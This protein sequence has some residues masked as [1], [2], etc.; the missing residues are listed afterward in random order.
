[1]AFDATK[2]NTSQ[3][4][5]DTIVSTNTNLNALKEDQTT[6]EADLTAHGLSAINSSV[7]TTVAHISDLNAHGLPAE[8]TRISNLETEVIA[9]RGT[10]ASLALRLAVGML[11]TGAIKLSSISSKW[12]NNSDVP[13]YL[14]S[15]TFSVPGSRLG[16]YIAGVQL[17]LNIAGSYVYA[18]V[19]SSSFGSGVTTVTLD[20]AYPV[21]TNGITSVEIALISY[22]NNMAAS[23]ATVQAEQILQSSDI[24][25]L[26]LEMIRAHKNGTPT[27]SEVLTRFYV[28]RATS[29]PSG[30]AG[31]GAKALVAAT[32]STTFNIQKNGSTVGT[33]VFAAAGTAATVTISSSVSLA[34]GDLVTI[35]APAS[36]D[37]TLANL[38]IAVKGILV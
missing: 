7:A 11:P 19:A 30:A 25:L 21:L 12:I 26:Q 24:D 17:R 22:D 9:S 28:N 23:I 37:A 4:I 29:L 32:A 38:A 5:G 8:R 10:A 34:V 6:H 20:P 3:T 36:P 2:P 16:V 33:I 14:T 27:A 35:V 13:T 31:S 18:P 1:M 15:T